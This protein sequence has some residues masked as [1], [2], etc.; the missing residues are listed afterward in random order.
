MKGWLKINRTL[1]SLPTFSRSDM[2]DLIWLSFI[3]FNASGD[4]VNTQYNTS[5]IPENLLFPK[6]LGKMWTSFSKC[7]LIASDLLQIVDLIIVQITIATFEMMQ[8]V[9]SCSDSL[10]SLRQQEDTSKSIFL[11]TLAEIKV[12]NQATHCRT[13]IPAHFI[14][15]FVVAE[16]F[17][18]LLKALCFYSRNLSEQNCKPTHSLEVSPLNR[19]G[20]S[21]ASDLCIVIKKSSKIRHCLH[22]R[23]FVDGIQYHIQYTFLLKQILTT[24]QRT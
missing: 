7:T 3:I 21:T 14:S 24:S 9:H 18:C 13:Q 4:S 16:K 10:W 23:K 15:F 6:L 11:P 22:L 19:N 5:N 2:T 17:V 8:I 1:G 12:N 20:K